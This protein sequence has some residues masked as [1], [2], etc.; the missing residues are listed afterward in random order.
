M[1]PF[2]L[3][4]ASDWTPSWPMPELGEIM[5]VIWRRSVDPKVMKEREVEHV[6]GQ[7]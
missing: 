5:M 6:V 1:K 4:D 2:P 3:V 7:K